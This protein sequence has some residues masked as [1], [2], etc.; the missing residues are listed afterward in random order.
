VKRLDSPLVHVDAT[1]TEEPPSE[2]KLPVSPAEPPLEAEANGEERAGGEAV[3]PAK[4]RAAA[5]RPRES[6]ERASDLPAPP[7]L[8]EPLEF[9][10]GRVPASLAQ[11]LNAMTLALRERQP[12]RASQKGLPQQEVLAVLLW[13]VGEPEDPAAIDALAELHACYRARRYAAA[14]EHLEGYAP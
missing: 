1:A 11:R 5:K 7:A 10:S 4:R 6:P 13:A 9:V 14:A 3:P 8:D 12:T 2:E